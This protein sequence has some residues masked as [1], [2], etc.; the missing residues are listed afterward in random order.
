[1]NLRNV[2]GWTVNA[3]A[4]IEAQRGAAAQLLAYV[5][6]MHSLEGGAEMKRLAIARSIFSVFRDP[7]KDGSCQRP[8]PDSW[9]QTISEAESTARWEPV[10]GTLEHA[11]IG[12]RLLR[13]L[14]S[15]ADTEVSTN[16]LREECRIAQRHA[17]GINFPANE[18][19][20]IPA[21]FA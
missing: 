12:E 4:P 20:T 15:S 11:A 17:Q 8:L 21:A 14:K 3:H 6:W 13:I 1:M 10:G 9:M 16:L 18:K 5:V 2:A 7:A 19:D